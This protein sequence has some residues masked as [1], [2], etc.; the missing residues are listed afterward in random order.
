M[1]AFLVHE[2]IEDC[3]R[4]GSRVANEGAF[5]VSFY[6]KEMAHDLLNM[7]EVL[8]AHSSGHIEHGY[9]LELPSIMCIDLKWMFIQGNETSTI[10]PT[11]R[12]NK[13]EE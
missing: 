13:K 7:D 11:K 2:H 12:R 4:T 5:N 6:N 8:S 1:I 9:G 10:F 3:W